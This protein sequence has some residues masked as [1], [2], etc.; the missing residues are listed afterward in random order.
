VLTEQ[1]SPLVSICSHIR[2]QND[3]APIHFLYSTKVPEHIDSLE[4]IL[5]LT[6]LLDLEA[7]AVQLGGPQLNFQLFATG[8]NVSGLLDKRYVVHRRME[9]EDVFLALGGLPER[10]STVCY[11]CGP[12]SM[13]DEFISLLKRQDGV[14]N[15]KILC[16]KWW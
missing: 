12:P 5:F 16:E 11:V 7:E 14:D 13:T 4:N 1:L 9:P 3:P 15:Q 2:E 8:D 6:R 10:K